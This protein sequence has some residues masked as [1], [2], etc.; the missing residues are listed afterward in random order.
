VRETQEQVQ[1]CAGGPSSS[2]RY[3]LYS[4]AVAPSCDHC[5]SSL[6]ALPPHS[7]DKG[8]CIL[9]SPGGAPGP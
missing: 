5:V 1:V 8:N 7:P 6:D 4:G 2:S 3:R 9:E